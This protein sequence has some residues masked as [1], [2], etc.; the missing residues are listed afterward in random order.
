[1]RRL[2]LVATI[3]AGLLFGASCSKTEDTAPETRLFG[4]PPEIQSV[5][6]SQSGGLG[7]AQC[8]YTKV[9]EGFLCMNGIALSD[10]DPI[11]PITVAVNYSELQFNVVVTDPDSVAGGQ[12][13]ILLVSASYQRS[14]QGGTPVETSLVI[15]DDGGSNSFNYSQQGIEIQEGC[16]D[17]DPG[18]VCGDPSVSCSSATYTLSSNDTT[19]G[20]GTFTRGFA[21]ISNTFN[22]TQPTGITLGSKS[23]LALN[24]VAND[25]SQ[26]PA[27]A[28]VALGQPVSFK[29]EA[30]DRAGNL[31]VWPSQPQGTFNQTSLSCTG[32]DCGCCILLSSV[33]DQECRGRAG[34]TGP[35]YPQGFCIG[36][37]GP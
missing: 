7:S 25:K 33:L 18:T 20:D 8:D 32:D 13:D 3:A 29:I 36:V 31:A 14:N 37:F 26:F 27:F 2:T 6:L 28:D 11:P 35:G 12:S 1:M 22:L 17:A 23:S 5:T 10:F 30:V 19:S 24:C 34:L 21:L 9:L 4:N 15:L 16:V